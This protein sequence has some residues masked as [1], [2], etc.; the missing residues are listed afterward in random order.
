MVQVQ[1]EIN[2]CIYLKLSSK[3]RSI[4]HAQNHVLFNSY[5]TVMPDNRRIQGPEESF[6]PLLYLHEEDKPQVKTLVEI[7]YVVVLLHNVSLDYTIDKIKKNF[8]CR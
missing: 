2:L 8:V 3:V 5:V 6:S 1:P 7:H 4:E